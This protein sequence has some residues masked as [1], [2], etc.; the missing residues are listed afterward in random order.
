MAKG[1]TVFS[2]NADE[3]EL[4]E[5]KKEILRLKSQLKQTEE[6]RDILKK[7][8]R[9]FSISLS[10]NTAINLKLKR[11]FGFLRLLVLAITPGC[12]N[13]NQAKRLKI[14]GYDSSSV[15]LMM[16]VM[17]SMGYRRITLDLKELGESCGPN[18]VLKIMMNNSFAAVR[19]YKKHK[20]YGRGRPQIVPSNHL[21]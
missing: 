8:A 13:P 17:V 11:C 20:S 15:L 5:V 4:L 3:H 16:P 6:E 12:M 19:G 7:A 9:Y 21:N 18:R 2:N 1:N 10:L 14:S